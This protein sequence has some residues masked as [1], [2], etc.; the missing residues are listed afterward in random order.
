MQITN[1][2]IK[3]NKKKKQVVSTLNVPFDVQPKFFDFLLNGKA[4]K[5]S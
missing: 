4:P 3:K 1:K 5:L 2:D